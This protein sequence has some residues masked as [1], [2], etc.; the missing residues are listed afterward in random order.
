MQI[1]LRQNTL[2]WLLV[3]L[4]IL[5]I[6]LTI[7]LALTNNTTYAGSF[8]GVD[9][10]NALNNKTKQEIK[11]VKSKYAYNDYYDSNNSYYSTHNR[12][13]YSGDMLS[14]FFNNGHSP[15]VTND[16]SRNFNAS[17]NGDVTGDDW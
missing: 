6:C 1:K 16:N 4:F 17:L 8:N 14:N 7:C 2:I 13:Y 5:T 11:R 3:S 15:N 10:V 12:H 9:D